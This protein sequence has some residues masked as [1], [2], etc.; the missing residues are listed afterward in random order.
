MKGLRSQAQHGGTV[1]A[2]LTLALQEGLIDTAIVAEDQE[3]FQHHGVAVSD[4]EEIGKRGKSKFIVSPTIAEFNK[5][6]QGEKQRIGVV[7]TPCQAQTLAKMRLKPI[8]TND[9]QI[10]KLKLVIGLF[11]G[12]TLSWRSFMDLLK[13]KT[14]LSDIIGMDIPPGKGLVEIYTDKETLS[15]PMEA[16][17]ACVREACHY[18]M[19]S[20][21]EFSRYLGRVGQAAG[22]LVGNQDLESGHSPVQTRTGVAGPGQVEGCSRIP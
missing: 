11:C 13:T 12:W 3:D 20:T 15:F 2:L 5:T 17:N 21:A 22:G 1:T 16:I 9:N 19:D 4:P 7:A 8:A 18:C 14:G 10:D 6:V